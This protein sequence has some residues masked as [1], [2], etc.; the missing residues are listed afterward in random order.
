MIP[1]ASALQ[2]TS[3]WFWRGPARRTPGQRCAA[4]DSRLVPRLPICP[5][6]QLRRNLTAPAR[7]PCPAFPTPRISLASSTAP[8]FPHLTNSSSPEKSPDKYHRFCKAQPDPRGQGLS[9]CPLRTRS[10]LYNPSAGHTGHYPFPQ[11]SPCWIMRSLN[12]VGSVYPSISGTQGC[13]CHL[14]GYPKCV[15]RMKASISQSIRPR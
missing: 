10:I 7:T 11:S 9:P 1:G 5:T 6:C 14:P 2:T 8:S 3:V 15:C 13:V 4:L 12:F